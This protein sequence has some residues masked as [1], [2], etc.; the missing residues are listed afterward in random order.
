M[1][2]WYR[3]VVSKTL[4]LPWL[5]VDRTIHLI[6]E[7]FQGNEPRSGLRLEYYRKY[8]TLVS[9]DIHISFHRGIK[10]SLELSNN[11][12]NIFIAIFDMGDKKKSGMKTENVRGNMIYF[13]LRHGSSSRFIPLPTNTRLLS[14][15]WEYADES[16]DDAE[17]TEEDDENENDTGLE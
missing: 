15:A 2:W 4:G 7:T 11:I 3:I 6:S 9:Y 5:Y 1:I 14:K 10:L 12:C 17:Q 16:V 8:L 13:P